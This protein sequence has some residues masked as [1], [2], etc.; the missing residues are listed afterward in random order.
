MTDGAE[1]LDFTDLSGCGMYLDEHAE[2][3]I[4]S[5]IS[6]YAPGGLH[7][8]D[9]GNY[10]Y[11]TRLFLSFAEEDFDLVV[12]D[13]HDDDIPPAFGGLKSCGSWI[14][15]IKNENRWLKELY[16]IKE[17]KDA[18]LILPSPRPL[19]ISVDKDVLSEDVLKTN[20]DQGDMTKEEFI[21]I[22]SYLIK[23]R[24]ILGI[25]ICG[26]DEAGKD[27]VK[28]ESFNLMII[29]LLNASGLFS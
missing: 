19:Y 15:D 4:L 7:F 2:A 1:I 8:I 17:K 20:W 24:L 27:T 22:F 12:F 10:H 18:D 21:E 28:N 3:A 29:Q 26:E 23:N 25:D 14:F 13:H 16:L 9:N 6:P 11:M 5:A